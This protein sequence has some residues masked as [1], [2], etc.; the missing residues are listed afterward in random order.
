MKFKMLY[1]AK[2]DG[3]NWESDSEMKSTIEDDL[4]FFK[5]EEDLK[6][7]WERMQNV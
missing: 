3:S 6:N 5:S 4:L 1:A 7:S 2:K